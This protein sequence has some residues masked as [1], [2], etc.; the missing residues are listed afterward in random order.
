MPGLPTHNSHDGGNKAKLM[1]ARR[2]LG[3]RDGPDR[4]DPAALEIVALHLGRSCLGRIGL[5]I[6]RHHAIDERDDAIGDFYV[7][8][9][10]AA[11][12]V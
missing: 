8:N 12:T 2:P 11:A 7:P 4:R 6:H 1:R 5:A 9:E 10:E 3:D